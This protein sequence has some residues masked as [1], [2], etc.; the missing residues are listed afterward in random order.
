[1]PS[2]GLV[3][4]WAYAVIA[5]LAWNLKTWLSILLPKRLAHDLRH[6]EYRRFLQ[7]VMLVPCQVLRRA[8]QMV[9]RLLTYTPWAELLL[10]GTQYFHRWRTA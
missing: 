5:T 2:D 6:M 9:L 8:R 4:N 10:S 3:S 1:M 7:S